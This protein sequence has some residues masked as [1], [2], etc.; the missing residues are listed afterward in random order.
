MDTSPL[1]LLRV[2]SLHF[3]KEGGKLQINYNLLNFVIIKKQKY[4][5]RVSLKRNDKCTYTF[6]YKQ[7]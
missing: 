2:A 3:A 4:E 1:P 5:A 7:K 6:A